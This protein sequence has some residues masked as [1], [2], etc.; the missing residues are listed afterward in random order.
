MASNKRFPAPAN[1]SAQ[2][3]AAPVKA[4]AAAPAPQAGMKA[5]EGKKQDLVQVHYKKKNNH[6]LS[7]VHSLG[8][9]I[10][11]VPRD[12]WESAKKHPSIQQMIM[13]EHIVEVGAAAPKAGK[14]KKDAAPKGD[15]DPLADSDP[16]GVESA[17]ASDASLA[18]DDGDP[19]V[20][21]TAVGGE[22]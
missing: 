1:K 19:A 13:D 5:V 2:S 4:A 14:G 7:A 22:E 9:G 17:S 20:S 3:K 21:D 15:S 12:V 18:E 8:E 16:A 11:H 10:N 6:I